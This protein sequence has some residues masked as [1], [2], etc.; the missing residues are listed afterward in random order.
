MATGFY[1]YSVLPPIARGIDLIR[2]NIMASLVDVDVYQA[3]YDNDQTIANVPPA[4]I[5]ATIPVPFRRIVGH[6][7]HA[8][9]LHF[10]SV[11]AGKKLRLLLWVS[12]VSPEDRLLILLLPGRVIHSNGGDITMSWPNDK[13]M[14][15]DGLY[16]GGGS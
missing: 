11:E 15:L 12:G 5:V 2:D 6:D 4:A 13:F 9:P 10:K 1:L 3:D 8:A 14:S 16:W 7:W